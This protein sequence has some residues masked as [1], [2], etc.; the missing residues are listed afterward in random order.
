MA[1]KATGPCSPRG[2][3]ASRRPQPVPER[4]IDR[5]RHRPRASRP[6]APRR[7]PAR[8]RPARSQCRSC[9]ADF[10]QKWATSHHGLAMQ[11]FTAALAKASLTP[12]GHA[13]RIGKSTYRAEISAQPAFVARDPRRRYGCGLSPGARRGRQERLLLPDAPG[14]R[15]IAGPARGLQ[16]SAAEMVRRAGQRRAAFRRPGRCPP[17]LAA[18]RV[19]LQYVVLRLPRQPAFAE[20]RPGHRQLPHHLGRAGNQ[21]RNLPRARGR[22]RPRVPARRAG[23]EAQGPEDHQ[24]GDS[25]RRSS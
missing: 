12:P 6:A 2:P 14:A 3:R 9:H 1:C 24:P 5:L 22:A 16:R 10:Y 7:R 8:R 20:L 25:S 4:P 21:L 13:I 17:G 18:Q 19:H 15:P 11:P 23:P